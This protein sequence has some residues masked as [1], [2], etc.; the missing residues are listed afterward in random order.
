MCLTFVDSFRAALHKIATAPET[1]DNHLFVITKPIDEEVQVYAKGLY[2]SS[3]GVEFAI[4]DSLHL[5]AISFICFIG[6]GWY[7]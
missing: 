2:E 5:F 6:H 3:G 1:I 4:L 7:S